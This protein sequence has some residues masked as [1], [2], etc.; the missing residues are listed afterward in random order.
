[1]PR[2][3][4]PTRARRAPSRHLDD[5]GTA[6]KESARRVRGLG[7]RMR[8]D[9]KV[10]LVTGATRGIGRSIAMVFAREG[11]KVVLAGRTV[12]AGGQLEAEIAA[13]G[14]ESGDVP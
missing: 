3:E 11:A 7:G 12:A 6:G 10:A 14:G 1:S 13:A 8:L 4:R 5:R 9:G 2:A